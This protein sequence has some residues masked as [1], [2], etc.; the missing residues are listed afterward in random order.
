MTFFKNTLATSAALTCLT[1]AGYADDDWTYNTENN[2]IGRI[3]YYERTNTDGSRDERVTV[4]RQDETHIAVYKEA[5]L[6]GNAALVTATLDFET[7]TTPVITGG[8]LMPDAEVMEFAFLNHDP[9]SDIATMDVRFPDMEINESAPIRNQTWHLFDFDLASLTMMTPHLADP[10]GN[11]SFGMALVWADQT[12]EDP[13]TWMGDVAVNYEGDESHIGHHTR[14][15]SLSGSAFEGEL[16]AGNAGALWLDAEDGHVV[17]AIFPAPNHP[18][19]TDFRLRLLHV[20]DGGAQ[21]WD[22]LLRAHWNNCQSN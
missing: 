14:R 16:A 18:G 21:E 9:G 7:F 22:E 5:S 8:R 20:S 10:A 19:Y 15:Y 3:Y 12:A 4:Y 17:D 2:A 1:S 13:F 6:C 11:F